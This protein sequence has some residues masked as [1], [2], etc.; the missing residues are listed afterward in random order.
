DR[1]LHL[2][3]VLAVG[4]PG[5]V[6]QE[7]PDRAVLHLRTA[8]QALKG[9][10]LEARGVGDDG[11]GGQLVVLAGLAVDLRLERRGRDEDQGGEQRHGAAPPVSAW[12]RERSASGAKTWATSRSRRTRFSLTGRS[13]VITR[14]LSKKTSTGPFSARAAASAAGASSAASA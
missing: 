6:L 12:M 2:A 4:Q 8:D 11:G 10:P 13:S 14:T 9:L 3:Q 1:A 7:L 5:P